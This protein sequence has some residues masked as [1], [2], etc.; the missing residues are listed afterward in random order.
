MKYLSLDSQTFMSVRSFVHHVTY[1]YQ[2]E[3]Q[4]EVMFVCN[5]G[6]VTS[7]LN[8]RSTRLVF[9]YVMSHVIPEAASDEISWNK[10]RGSP[11]TYWLS[12]RKP[13]LLY[14]PHGQDGAEELDML[15]LQWSKKDVYVYRS[16]NGSTLVVVF[17]SLDN[18][19]PDARQDKERKSLLDSIDLYSK[20]HLY[21]LTAIVSKSSVRAASCS[22]ADRQHIF[23]N[24]S[25]VTSSPSGSNSD[26]DSGL[27]FLYY[28][29][30][31]GAVKVLLPAPSFQRQGS[32]S[33]LTLNPSSTTSTASPLSCWAILEADLRYVLLPFCNLAA[34]VE[35]SVLDGSPGRRIRDKSGEGVT[36]ILAKTDID[37]HW[38][39]LRRCDQRCLFATLCAHK[40]LNLEEVAAMWNQKFSGTKNPSLPFASLFQ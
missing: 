24:P 2:M 4:M 35:D 29:E 37:E 20:Q 38:V 8:L 18:E 16:V 31:N 1:S 27:Y 22:V 33:V 21:N 6:L 36:E 25:P 34:A 28:N 10:K 14:L 17:D 40:N 7:T 26:T 9:S 13:I 3:P 32:S 11:L 12:D 39:C 30:A 19:I 5:D 15:Q 23:H